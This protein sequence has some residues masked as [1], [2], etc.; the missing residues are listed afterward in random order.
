MWKGVILNLCILK[1]YFPTPYSQ[2][3]FEKFFHHF[4]S[5]VFPI[6]F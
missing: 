1:V 2:E 6:E 3:D 4:A 5:H